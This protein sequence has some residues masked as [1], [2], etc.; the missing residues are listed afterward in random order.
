MTT[1]GKLKLAIR[2]EG[3]CINAYLAKIDGTKDALL[4]G[5]MTVAAAEL[6]RQLFEDFKGL[7]VRTMTALVQ[8]QG[9]TVLGFEESPAPASEQAGH[10]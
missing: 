3:A 8:A 6:D 1:T 5:H 2:K 7:M 4:I 10:A 9:A